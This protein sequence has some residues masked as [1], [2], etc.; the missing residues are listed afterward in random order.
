MTKY[1][2]NLE[3]FYI[4]GDGWKNLRF[5]YAKR[6]GLAR[7]KTEWGPLEDNPDSL[8]GTLPEQ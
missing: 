5:L 7:T 4:L 2:L 8:N 6:F 1:I 3:I